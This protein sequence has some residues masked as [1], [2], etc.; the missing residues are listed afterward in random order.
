MFKPTQR[1]REHVIGDL[2]ENWVERVALKTGFASQ[3]LSGFA[4]YG[5]DLAIITVD[6]QGAVEP[7]YLLFQ[8][9][10]TDHPDE[11]RLKTDSAYSFPIRVRHLML[12]QR[13]KMPV[14]VCFYDAT[15]EVAYWSWIQR[16]IELKAGEG[17]RITKSIRFPVEHVLNEEAFRLFAKWKR[18]LEQMP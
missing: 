11:Y 6:D 15:K 13:E 10:A 14:I 17:P 3:R 9:K 5:I 12:W 1:T 8:V 18:E 4:D 7:G 2:G 16:E